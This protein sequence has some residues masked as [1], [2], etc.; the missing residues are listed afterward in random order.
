MMIEQLIQ[1]A[2]EEKGDFIDSNIPKISNDPKF[3]SWAKDKGLN[4]KNEKVRDL[5]VSLLEKTNV[6]DEETKERLYSLMSDDPNSYV[7]FRSAFALTRHKYAKHPQ[8]VI[9]VLKQAAQDSDVKE[10]AEDYLKRLI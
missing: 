6:L 4:D 9:D 10:I 2:K 3:I 5:A 7:R 1:A 8:E